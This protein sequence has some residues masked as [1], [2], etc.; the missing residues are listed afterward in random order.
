MKKQIMLLLLFLITQIS[1]ADNLPKNSETSYTTLAKFIEITESLD[2]KDREN[3]VK[4]EIENI[5]NNF[6]SPEINGEN[7]LFFY[8]D[9]VAKSVNL[10]GDP[11]RWKEPGIEMKNIKGTSVFYLNQKF[12]TNARLKYRFKIQGKGDIV[13]PFNKKPIEKSVFGKE[14]ILEMND[15]SSFYKETKYYE[16]IAH[17]KMVVKNI[18]NN[19]IFGSKDKK[20][21]IQIYLPPNY[22]EKTKYKTMYFCDGSDYVNTSKIPN[23]LDY[24][25]NKGEIEPIVAVFVDWIERDNEYINETRKDYLEFLT[26]ELIPMMESEFSL[27]SD[28]EGRVA[29]GPSNG[30]VFV[31]YV[32][33]VASDKFRYILNQS[34]G[35]DFGAFGTINW[36]MKYEKENLPIKV[37]SVAGKYEKDYNR[38][39]AKKFHE[40]LKNNPT[41]I[42]EKYVLYPEGHTYTMW[43]DSFREGILW[44]LYNKEI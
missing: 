26:D 38:D 41:I 17:G 21:K 34:G 20:R 33:A 30:G 7:A 39:G 5:K 36:G 4:K 43:G 19:T 31:T 3:F 28:R 22:N 42:G 15:Y 14:S 8:R 13:D 40:Y 6:S 24:M 32:G 1:F 44:L 29:V 18:Q 35:P 10:F 27:I 23:V 2:I 25:I 11:T 9:S 12:E 16:N 37:F